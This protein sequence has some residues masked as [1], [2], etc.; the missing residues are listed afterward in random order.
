M[1]DEAAS[2][3]SCLAAVETGEEVEGGK[4]RRGFGEASV[5]PIEQSSVV[6]VLTCE[7]FENEGRRLLLIV[8]RRLLHLTVHVSHAAGEERGEEG[9]GREQKRVVR[10]NGR[11]RTERKENDRT[12]GKDRGIVGGVEI[13]APAK[14]DTMAAARR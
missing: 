1:S 11:E 13:V 6:C 12:G 2:N 10:N 3:V 5:E 7:G 9:Q 14:A 8:G 4:G